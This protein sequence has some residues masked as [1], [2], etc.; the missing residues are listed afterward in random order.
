MRSIHPLPAEK[1]LLLSHH[2]RL[3]GISFQKLEAPCTLVPVWTGQQLL[4]DKGGP[5]GYCHNQP[6]IPEL[7]RAGLKAEL[8]CCSLLGPNVG[9]VGDTAAQ[10][11]WCVSS[12]KPPEHR[13][14]HHGGGKRARRRIREAHVHLPSC[15]RGAT[16][17]L[18]GTGSSG[19]R[20]RGDNTATAQTCPGACGG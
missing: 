10:S 12:W 17:L 2:S 4:Q 19:D 15:C 8:C 16:L 7:A 1:H 13:P 9:A 20:G 3:D 5:C 11:P 14:H 18:D 6:Y